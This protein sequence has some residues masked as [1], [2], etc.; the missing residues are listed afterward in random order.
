MYNPTGCSATTTYTTADLKMF[1]DSDLNYVRSGP[2][3][4]VVMMTMVM[5]AVV[6]HGASARFWDDHCS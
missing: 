6:D 5:I 1:F 3:V 4:V 2:P